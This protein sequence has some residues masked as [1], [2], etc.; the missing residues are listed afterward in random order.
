MT[1]EG[2]VTQIKEDK[3]ELLFHEKFIRQYM[4]G[5]KLD[6]RFTISRSNKSK[7]QKSQ[8]SK[9]IRFPV[10]NMHR[11]VEVASEP[12]LPLLPLLFPKEDQLVPA[13][14]GLEFYKSKIILNVENQT[15]IKV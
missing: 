13:S 15:I 9:Q 11:A 8:I 10:R 6:V 12:S 4:K 5:I 7:S 1:Y 2:Y 3:V 14:A